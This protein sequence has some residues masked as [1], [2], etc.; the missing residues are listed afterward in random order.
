MDKTKSG[1]FIAACK[2]YFGL[3]PDESSMQFAQEV[4]QLTDIDRAEI[5][6]GLCKEGYAII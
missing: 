4:K 5:K 2:D 1:S 3:L 6:E